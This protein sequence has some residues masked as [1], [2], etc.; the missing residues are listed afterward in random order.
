MAQLCRAVWD[1]GSE[2][3]TLFRTKCVLCWLLTKSLDFCR[4][5]CLNCFWNVAVTWQFSLQ[6]VL[7][8]NLRLSPGFGWLK[9]EL[10]HAE[11]HRIKCK[12]NYLTDYSAH[13]CLKEPPG[14]LWQSSPAGS[15]ETW[16][17][18]KGSCHISP[19]CASAAARLH[20]CWFSAR[21]TEGTQRAI[22]SSG[23]GNNLSNSSQ[24]LE[25]VSLLP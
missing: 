16:N 5:L 6:E 20:Q 17:G 11:H 25:Q 2:C 18:S 12:L 8:A 3:V 1:P 14:F 15:S 22:K 23:F 24:P 9:K 13:Y 7:T 19:G 10:A 21:G 4:D